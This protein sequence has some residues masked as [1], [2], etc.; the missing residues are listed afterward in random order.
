[1][2]SSI[3]SGLAD[4]GG[5]LTSRMRAVGLRRAELYAVRVT[6]GPFLSF[7]QNREDVVL[8]RALRGVAEGRYVDVG[9]ND[10]THFSVTR[11]FYDRGWSGIAIE[12]V[13]SFAAAFRA[14][15]PRDQV[16]EAV[17]ADKS[18][19]EV[20]LHSV[21]GTGLSTLVD[22]VRDRHVGDGR[23]V[24]DI[25]VARHTLDDVLQDAGWSGQDIHFVTIDTEGSERSV[26][27]GFDL[28]R[29]RPWILVVEATA[30]LQT[31]ETHA[32]WEDLVLAAGYRFCLFDGL[33]RFYV[34]PEK[35]DEI[36]SALSRPANVFD[37]YSTPEQR[38]AVAKIAA[39]SQAVKDREDE[40]VRWRAAALTRFT[41]A[42]VSGLSQQEIDELHRT[43]AELHNI[44]QT[45]SWRLTRPLRA[46]RARMGRE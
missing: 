16:V 35:A 8:G 38:N 31:A 42:S 13:P 15:R 45:V 6:A 24:V 19:G 7:A 36:G 30:P 27:L 11:A 41:T 18:G 4:V 12:P 25:S 46:I 29:W 20:V 34:S 1:M 44:R 21:P 33:S 5:Y 3:G 43:R 28:A 40:L 22:D 17:V 9:A 39:A 14:A 23:E 37:D 32:E 26:L 10:P 2:D